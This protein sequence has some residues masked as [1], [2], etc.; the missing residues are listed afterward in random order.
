MFI[1]INAR[2]QKKSTDLNLQSHRSRYATYSIT[3][4]N[5]FDYE[6]ERDLTSSMFYIITEVNF[7]ILK[8]YY[9]FLVYRE[10]K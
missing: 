1:N 7:H 10:A 2:R 4:I 8:V 6:R 3:R 9:N 5:L